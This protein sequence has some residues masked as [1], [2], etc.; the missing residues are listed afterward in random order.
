MSK[1]VK[2]LFLVAVAITLTLTITFTFMGDTRE[3]MLI[4]S[5]A[6]KPFPKRVSRFL[7]ENKNPRAADHCNKDNEIC[8]I[9]EGKNSTCCNNKCMDLSEDKHNCGACKR[10]VQVYKLVLQRGVCEFGL[11]QEALRVVW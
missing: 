7:A 9:L 11:R 10:Q 6:V 8:Y 3:K 1:I 2:L 4:T 5:R